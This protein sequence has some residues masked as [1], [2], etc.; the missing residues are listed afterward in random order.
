M[1]VARLWL[2]VL[3]FLAVPARGDSGRA[4]E[5]RILAAWNDAGPAERIWMRGELDRIERA[6][7]YVEA[8]CV[9]VSFDDKTYTLAELF[10]QVLDP[11]LET[12]LLARG[13]DDIGL[14]KAHHDAMRALRVLRA[15]HRAP[16]PVGTA[17]LNLMLGYAR[18]VLDAWVLSPRARL[19][20]LME[21]LENVRVLEGRAQPDARTAWL[22][23]E[24]ILPSLL[25]LAR[26]YADY[27]P[28]QEAISKAASR[29]SMPSVLEP[30]AIA[31]LA[32]LT[33]SSDSRRLLRSAYRRGNLPDIGIGAL[34]R[35]VIA[36]AQDDD[37]YLAGAAPLLLELLGDRR[38]SARDRGKMVDL[39]IERYAAVEVLRPLAE[40]LLAAAYGAPPAPLTEWRT[41]REASPGPID[42]P[43]G[44]ET[45]RLL[46]VVMLKPAAGGP[47]E[48]ALVVRSDVPY[49]QPVHSRSG[50]FLGMLVPSAHGDHA[51][52]VGP[53]PRLR[54]AMDNRIVRR[55]LR[56][57]QLSVRFEGAHDE[58]IELYVALPRDG[59]EPIP[60]DDARLE[61]VLA[62]V[63]DRL[64]STQDTVENRALV[65]LLVRIGTP[66]ARRMA[67]RFARSAEHASSLLELIEDGDAS[68]A[69]PLLDRI[70]DLGDAERMRA[71][72][73]VLARGDATLLARVAALA[74][75]APIDIAAPAADALLNAGDAAGVHALLRHKDRYARLCGAA[76]ALRLTP[77]AQGLR[78]VPNKPVDL[79]AL[80]KLATAAFP[81]AMGGAWRQLGAWLPTAL[82]DPDKAR[83]DRSAYPSL[84]A[85]KGRPKVGPARFAQIWTAAIKGGKAK[86]RWP[87]LVPYVLMP[88]NP[89]RGMK[90]RALEALLDALEAKAGSDPLRRAWI[91]S[92][93][94]L[95][96]VQSGLEFDTRFLELADKRLR[97]VAGQKT[98]RQAARKP[99]LAWP[100]WAARDLARG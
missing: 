80:A 12:P 73:A 64:E 99:G 95:A 39:I 77:L 42:H 69:G 2:P 71:F 21:V 4:E 98:P 48:P 29:L 84:F 55:T 97:R 13:D 45:F 41:R 96:A 40:N 38:V 9:L 70:A 75:D 17:T 35:S 53:T 88:K 59:S 62:F 49:F 56:L 27:P 52:F 1:R 32:S 83:T 67:V 78:I 57:G 93:V 94:V 76:L 82:T 68:A 81:K 23:R 31:T 16:A 36:D 34:A 51:D 37:A 60:L 8:R 74:A 33:T 11:A 28:V 44:G 26:R 100:I 30:T 85:G 46:Q 22:V 89:G 19:N 50:E 87:A 7:A 6:R 5:A 72:G 15:A 66:A 63:R 14:Q 58:E 65:G 92:L 18:R 90:P 20:L 25:G 24:A 86:G 43:R 3:L 61:H 10:E 79:A 47:P 54:G 91:D